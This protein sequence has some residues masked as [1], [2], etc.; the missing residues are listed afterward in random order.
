[1]Y[2]E[3]VNKVSAIQT[4]DTSAL[5]KKSDYDTKIEEKISD[6]DKC[7]TTQKLNLILMRN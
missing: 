3:L 4:I 5:A 2:D 7:I 6:H 1:M